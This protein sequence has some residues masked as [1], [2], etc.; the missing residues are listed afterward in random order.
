MNVMNKRG[1]RMDPWEIP[2]FM[3]LATEHPLLMGGS[4]G[5]VVEL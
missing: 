4:V 3:D 1:P 5:A 2:A